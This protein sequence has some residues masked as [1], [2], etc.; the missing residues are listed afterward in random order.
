MK[1]LQNSDVAF[2]TLYS[3]NFSDL[4][5]WCKCYLLSLTWFFILITSSKPAPN[6]RN[7]DKE[8]TNSKTVLKQGYNVAELDWQIFDG[9]KNKHAPLW[10]AQNKLHLHLLEQYLFV[11]ENL[12]F[13][14]NVSLD[15]TRFDVSKWGPPV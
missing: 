9:C 11:I 10:G 6:C 5:W 1:P 3:N 15:N 14:K 8:N 7:N 2:H 13:S 12:S 4:R